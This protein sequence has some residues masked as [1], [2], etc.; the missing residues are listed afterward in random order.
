MPIAKLRQDTIRSLPYVGE[1]NAQCIYW[2]RS[3]KGFGLRVFGGGRRTYVCAYRLHRRRR[4]A[5]LGRADALTLDQARK[6]ALRYLGQV[7]NNADPQSQLDGLA[8]AVSV[9]ELIAQY[10]EQHAKKKKKSW[11]CDQNMLQTHLRVLGARPAIS[12]ATAQIERIHAAY[13]TQFPYAANDLVC[14]V[15][16]MFNWGRLA[17]LVPSDMPNPGVG[18]IRFPER[19]RR[20]FVTTVEMP[21][22]LCALEQE[23]NEFAR[24]AIWLLL[25]IGLRKSELLR[26]RWKDVD[27]DFKTLFIGL[28]KNGEPVLA[29]LSDAAIDRLKL[30][31]RL[32]DNDYII[33]GPKPASHLKDL[34]SPW[35]RVRQAAGLQDLRIH[36]LRRT[37]GSWLVQH[38]ESLHLVGAVL[39]HKDAKTTAGYAYFQTQQRSRAL[40]AHGENILAFA[41]ATVD[42]SEPVNDPRFSA[43][44][45]YN[46]PL[47]DPPA[48]SAAHYV[49]REYLH[50][51]VWESPVSEVAA[52]F[53]ISDVGLAKACRR[54]AIPIPPRGYWARLEAGQRLDPAPLPAAPTQY[55]GKIR[56]KGRNRMETANTARPKVP[57]AA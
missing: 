20:R 36:D 17:G 15:R 48:R 23:E 27:W 8:A 47:S 45:S 44:T 13:G 4:I 12:V 43:A 11:K 31:P 18:I 7:A 1:D 41:P 49:T 19:R 32:A 29:P 14:I 38:G 3:L 39:N 10:V 16:K 6:K 24:H 28:T 25:L 34:A 35:Q 52:R 21:R 57:V 33:C 54:A 46:A 42:R 22:L 26:A 55:L 50:Q 53:E 40:T 9:R 51:L 5:T 37:V 56:I 30:I 2:D